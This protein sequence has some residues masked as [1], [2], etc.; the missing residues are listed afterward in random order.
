MRNPPIPRPS[1]TK[2]DELLS[3]IEVF[4]SKCAGLERELERKSSQSRSRKMT[5]GRL[6]DELS[7]ARQIA[8]E[9][10]LRQLEELQT[11][12]EENRELKQKLIDLIRQQQQPASDEHQHGIYFRICCSLSIVLWNIICVRLVRHFKKSIIQNYR[13]VHDIRTQ[14]RILITIRCYCIPDNIFTMI[15]SFH[16]KADAN[17]VTSAV[18]RLA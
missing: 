7:A 13:H 18:G 1:V 11:L 6:T 17:P 16:T 9:T 3:Q 15:K 5:I 14:K 4:R 2:E 12:T 10:Q 8:A